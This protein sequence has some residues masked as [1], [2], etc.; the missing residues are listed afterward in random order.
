[1]T[2]ARS[3][4]EGDYQ[5]AG[6]GSIVQKGAFLSTRRAK[7]VSSVRILGTRGI[8]AGHGGFE[9][10]AQHLALHLVNSNVEVT[11]YCQNSKV[12]NTEE[13]YWR[14]VRCIQIPAGES[15]LGSIVFDAKAM[16]HALG[17][18]GPLYTLGYNTAF[19][20]ILPWL[21]RRKNLI[22]MDGLEW[23]RSKWSWVIKAWFYINERIAVRVASHLMADN[24]EIKA[25]LVAKGTPADRISVAAYGARRITHAPDS[26]LAAFGLVSRSYALVV[27]R[28]EPENS[29]LEI[30]RAFRKAETGLKLVVLGRYRPGENAYHK[31]VMDSADDTVIFPGPIFEREKID[32]LRYHC[33]LYIHGHQVGGTNPSLVEALG[34]SSAVLAF[35]NVFNRWTA[36]TAAAYFSGEDDCQAHIDRL[37][38]PDA[39]HV[40]ETMR[41]RS[42]KKFSEEFELKEVMEKHAAIIGTG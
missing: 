13:T 34:A 15:A 6:D 28:P 35:D 37:L 11:V 31:D 2:S 25:Y 24:P 14:G 12:Q 21:L 39:A 17:E 16:F 23:K 41:K 40:L 33:R 22:N 27:A 19:L 5:E 42:G 7:P 30:V 26:F 3:K 36:G 10:Y 8:P 1:V 9:V 38:R 32:C 29:I 20:N 18:A 4:L